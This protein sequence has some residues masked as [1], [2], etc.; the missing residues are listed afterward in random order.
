MHLLH[1][2]GRKLIKF[3]MCQLIVEGCHTGSP[4]KVL[5][6]DDDTLSNAG[7][8]KAISEAMGLQLG[9]HLHGT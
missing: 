3:A 1:K 9:I 4:I 8:V 7:E 6:V 5:I 2:N